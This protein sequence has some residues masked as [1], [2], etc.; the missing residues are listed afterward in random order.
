MGFSTQEYWSGLPLPSPGDLPDPGMEPMSPALAGEFFT[1]SPT[2]E[3]QVGQ[4][5][6]NLNEGLI[7]SCRGDIAAER[8][9]AFHSSEKSVPGRRHSSAKAL[10]QEGGDLREWDGRTWYTLKGCALGGGVTPVTAIMSGPGRRR[11]CQADRPQLRAA[12]HRFLFVH[13]TSRMPSRLASQ[14]AQVLELQRAFT[15]ARLVCF[16]DPPSSCAVG[17]PDVSSLRPFGGQGNWGRDAHGM[18]AVAC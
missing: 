11:G 6:V 3:A 7:D 13:S 8:E 12:L 15:P 4:G 14:H 9:A 2:W 16:F 1:T 18:V 10:S 17:W 5:E